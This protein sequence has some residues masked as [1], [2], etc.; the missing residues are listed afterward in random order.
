[1]LNGNDKDETESGG[2]EDAFR[3]E[4]LSRSAVA[5]KLGLS[6]KAVTQLLIDAGWLIQEDGAWRLTAKGEFEGGVYRKSQ[7]YGNYIVW[8]TSILS[9][10]IFEQFIVSPMLSASKLAKH[11]YL[12]SS[13]MNALLR[14]LAWQSAL[15]KGW[16]LTSRGQSAGGKQEASKKTGVP[17]V[18]WPSAIVDNE[19]L[20][21]AVNRLNGGQRTLTTFIGMDGH[22]YASLELCRLAN[23]FYVRQLT[24]GI[25]RILADS[26]SADFY[27]PQ[28]GLYV[29]LN[30]SEIDAGQLSKLIDRQSFYRREHLNYIELSET[31][32][33]YLESVLPKIL[34]EH[35]FPV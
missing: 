1:M 16:S 22:E 18:L 10:G 12:P 23:W 28:V 17:Y 13:L 4:W 29:D 26:H 5:E 24:F 3:H 31:D 35:D 30:T 32:W 7:K 15:H 20:K 34:L 25:N 11:F 33:D 6:L 14:D 27:L 19:V 8:P 9:H 2:K 21:S